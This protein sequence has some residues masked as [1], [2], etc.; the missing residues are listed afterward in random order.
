[1]LSTRVVD[2]WSAPIPNRPG[3]LLEKLEGLAKAGADLEILD[4]RRSRE[5][6]DQGVT[7][8]APLT[9]EAQ[10]SAAKQ[11]GFERSGLV[12]V[13]VSCP[14]E[15]GKGYLIVRAISAQGINLAGVVGTGIRDELIMY[16]AFDTAADAERAKQV[17]NRV[18]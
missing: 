2:V 9:G 14:D 10:I 4:A 12:H 15:P 17:L 7:F 6:P 18:P 3:G 5:N 11:L 16:L 8:L 13:R 1:M